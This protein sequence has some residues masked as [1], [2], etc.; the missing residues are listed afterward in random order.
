[1]G[2]FNLEA[3][4]SFSRQL[5][6]G[7]QNHIGTPD[8]PYVIVVPKWFEAR[9]IAEGTT[10]QAVYDSTFRGSSFRHGRVEVLED[11]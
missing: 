4:V 1:M 6:N 2:E 8:N 3:V 5:R 11:Y 10:P 9:C 7:Y